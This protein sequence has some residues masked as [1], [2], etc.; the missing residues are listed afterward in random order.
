M[1]FYYSSIVVLSTIEKLNIEKIIIEQEEA[2]ILFTQ[3]GILYV[4]LF[5][6]DS[7]TYKKKFPIFVASYHFKDVD[8]KACYLWSQSLLGLLH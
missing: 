1:N 5:T 3:E 6:N 8:S 2:K 7:L 4:S